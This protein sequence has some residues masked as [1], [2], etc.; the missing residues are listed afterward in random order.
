MHLLV[1]AIL[2]N[3][4]LVILAEQ[5][6]IIS[7]VIYSIFLLCIYDNN[8]KY[9]SPV[10]WGSTGSKSGYNLGK[11]SGHTPCVNLASVLLWI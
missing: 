4:T 11:Q 1:I 5:N 3:V 10:F 7:I 6:S 8:V 9:Y 2:D